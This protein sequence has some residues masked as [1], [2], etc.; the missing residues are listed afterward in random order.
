MRAARSWFL[1]VAFLQGSAVHGADWPQFLGPSR[2]GHSPETGLA[3]Q[4]PANGYPVR[5]RV[6]AGAGFSGPVVSAAKVLLFHQPADEETLTC[7][8]QQTGKVLW[9]TGYPSDYQGGYGTGPGPRA[10]P[11]VSGKTVY[12]LG[13]AGD[14]QAVDFQTGVRQWRRNLNDDFRVPEGYFGVAGSPVVSGDLLLVNVGGPKAGLAAFHR[15]DG[16][17]AWQITDDRA[18]YS[19]PIVG[20]AGGK[21]RAFFFARSGLHA[22]N[23]RDGQDH[24]FF[25][26]RARSDASVN[27]ATPLLFDDHVF[28]SASYNT[29]AVLLKVTEAGFAKVWSSGEH[30]CNHYNT[31]VLVDGHLYGIDGRQE[32]GAR[33]ECLDAMTGKVRWSEEGFGCAS[34]IVADGRLWCWSEAGEL[35]V[36][37]PSPS[38]YT[39]LGKSTYGG[40][41]CRAHPALANGNVFLRTDRE[42]LC[43]DIAGSK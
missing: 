39:A 41:D 30:L 25:P 11:T 15:Q 37:L 1:V 3:N 32:G 35:V 14:L 2:D 33:L 8:D 26:W 19:S 10:T 31:S 43:V 28:L 36:I 13:A 23:P 4:V 5:W 12:T 40:R 18:S 34:I 7:L 22:V 16:T 24:L 29:G 17:T 20:H 42:L 9:S 21:T 27:A 6:P 38:R